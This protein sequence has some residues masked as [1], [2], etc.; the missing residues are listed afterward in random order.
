SHGG[1]MGIYYDSD[2]L[3][4][5]TTYYFYMHFAE[6]EKLQKNQHREFDID[7]NYSEFFYKSLDPDYLDT[8]TIF[9]ENGTKPHGEGE[10]QIWFNSTENSTL[11][12]L[13]NA[14]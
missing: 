13:I 1:D 5:T 6:L 4:R 11:P 7:I 14:L 3:D 10:I 8:I 2:Q 9:S 12:L